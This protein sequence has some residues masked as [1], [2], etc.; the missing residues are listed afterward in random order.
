MANK[1][2]VINDLHLGV[3]RSAGTTLTSADE[4][5][6]YAMNQYRRLLGMGPDNGCERVIVN[7][8]LTDAYDIPLSQALE[9]Y[10]VTHSFLH[11]HPDIELDWSLGNHDLSKDS[12]KLGTVAF[13]GALLEMQHHNFRVVSSACTLE[14]ADDI[15]IIPHV[16]NQDVFDFELSRV[17][18]GVKFLLLHCNYDN[19]F[20]CASDHSL[21][22]SR[23]QAKELKNR[24]MTLVLGHEHQGR[25]IFGRSVVIVGNQFPTS[26]ADCLSHGEGQKDGTKS[27]LILDHDTNS[28]ERIHT[29]TPDDADGWFARVEWD[30][31]KDVEEEGRGFVRVSGDATQEQS[32]QVVKAISAFRNRSKSFVVANAVRVEKDEGMDDLSDSIEDIRSVNVIEL[33]LK[34]LDEKQ[35]AA[36]LALLAE[37]ETA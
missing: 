14:G 37:K 32:A 12:S 7:G 29:W 2:L 10:E 22:I 21:N 17:P 20:A 19:T 3:Q 13:I 27:A 34:E 24:G 15:Y 18:D 26:I 8:D 30:E 23:D 5:R 25:E 1:T 31:L 4:L 33:L 35:G 16:V 6:E 28:W 11:A 9:L 36:V